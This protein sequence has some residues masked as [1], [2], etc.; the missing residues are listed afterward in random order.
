MSQTLPTKG[1]RCPESSDFYVLTWSTRARPG[2][3]YMY[4]SRKNTLRERHVAAL[5]RGTRSHKEACLCY[6]LQHTELQRE[7]GSSYGKYIKKIRKE[8][9]QY[10]N[11]IASGWCRIRSDFSHSSQISF[12]CLSITFITTCTKT[13]C[14]L[15]KKHVVGMK[16]L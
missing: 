2:Q 11:L 3:S 7:Y 14:T 6:L 9:C 8:I 13:L 4:D 15:L 1:T 10:V 12:N 16:C 5:H